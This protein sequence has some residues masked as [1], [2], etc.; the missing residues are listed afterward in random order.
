MSI[1]KYV[2]LKP[3]SPRDEPHVNRETT[4]VSP[5]SQDSHKT[6]TSNFKFLH[7]TPARNGFR[8]AEVRQGMEACWMLGSAAPHILGVGPLSAWP[9][10]TILCFIIGWIETITPTCKLYEN[11]L[12]LARNKV[13]YDFKRTS[14]LPISGFCIKIVCESRPKDKAKSWDRSSFSNLGANVKIR[15]EMVDQFRIFRWRIF[16]R[17][18]QV[19]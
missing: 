19:I 17:R 1:A 9:P 13:L 5:E 10:R 2:P 15:N 11:R 3:Q 4:E 8:T 6:E 7:N 12:N 18:Y 14:E 16:K